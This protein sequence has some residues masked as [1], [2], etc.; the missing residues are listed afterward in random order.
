[1]EDYLYNG[2]VAVKIGVDHKIVV[3]W[4]VDIAIEVF[5]H[6][7]LACTVFSLNVSSCFLQ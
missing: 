3:Q 1:M 5:F 6:V 2:F 4:V 7:A